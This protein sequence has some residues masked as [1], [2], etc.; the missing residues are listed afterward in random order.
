V[1]PEALVERVEQAAAGAGSVLFL[2]PHLDDA[3]L[4]C[5]AL[6]S[7][8]VRSSRVVVVTVFSA[9]GPPPH[10]LAARSFLRQC[11]ATGAA[12]LYE[13]RHEEDAEVMRRLGAEHLHLDVPDALFR[14][15][16]MPA[17]VARLGRVVP[18]LVHRYPT[19]RFDIDRG[20]ISRGDR[21][22]LEHLHGRV[23]RIA[24]EVHAGLIFCPIGVGRHVDHLLTR[25]VGEGFPGQVVYYSDFPY[26]QVQS[27]DHRYVS[28]HRLQPCAWD[29]GL[30]R[31]LE[32]IQGY[33]TQ[34]DALFPTGAIA[35]A[36][37]VYFL[38]SS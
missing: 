6:M 31:K 12:E 32:L 23:R 11:S 28:D 10:T 38:A 25:T 19:F 16:V 3:V 14:K 18:E 26:N 17:S 30:A 5:G 4:S 15:R 8:L 2:S 9:A 29:D 35:V 34:V 7:W 27:P 21:V 13:G 22:L 33:R 20:R 36:P 1:I 37:E 24:E